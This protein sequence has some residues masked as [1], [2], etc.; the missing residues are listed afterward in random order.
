MYKLAL[1]IRK[2]LSASNPQVYEPDLANSYNNLGH[3]YY[4][5]QRFLESEQMYKLALEIRK[6][7]SVSNSLVY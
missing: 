5:T 2:R 7:L 6:R 4:K 1:E 3:L